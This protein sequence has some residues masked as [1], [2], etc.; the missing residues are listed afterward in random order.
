M[1][2]LNRRLK[3]FTFVKYFSF[4]LF[5]AGGPNFA[6]IWKIVPQLNFFDN[7]TTQINS[8]QMINFGRL[9]DF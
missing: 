9:R 1:H 6:R 8:V 5:Q 2:L 7:F 4:Y 3:L